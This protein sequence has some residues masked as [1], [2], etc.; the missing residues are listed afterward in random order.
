VVDAARLGQGGIWVV[1][2]SREVHGRDVKLWNNIVT[3]NNSNRTVFYQNL[4]TPIDS[5]YNL[6]FV[7]NAPQRFCR[8][9]S[10]ETCYATLSA[11]QQAAGADAHSL[12]ADPLLN[13][14]DL[15]KPLTA[16]PAIDRG[17][18]ISEVTSDYS[19][20]PRPQGASYDIGAHEAP[21]ACAVSPAGQSFP[22]IASGGSVYV[23]GSGCNWTAASNASWITVSSS[24]SGTGNGTVKYTVAANASGSPRTGMLTVAGQPVIVSQAQQFTDVSPSDVYY[25]YIS[26]IAARGVTA[27]CASGQY[28]PDGLVPR[29]Q[30]AVFIER[31]LGV[32]TPP[33]PSGQTFLDVPPSRWSYTFIED[34]AKRGITVGCGGGYFCPDS[35]VPRDQM[36]TFLERA[37]GR[38]HPA[39][40][41][42]QRFLDVPSSNIFYTFIDSFVAHGAP[43][44]V[45]GVIERGCNTDGQHFCPNNQLS[46]AEMAPWLVV[47]FGLSPGCQIAYSDTAQWRNT[48]MAPKSGSF[49]AELDAAPLS[50]AEDT[51]IALS[52]GSQTSWTGLA[53]IV[54]FNTGNTMDVRNGGI[55]QAQTTVPYTPNTVYHIRM[56]VNVIAHTYSVYVTP[57]GGSEI[58]LAKN[59]AFRTEQQTVSSLNNWVAEAEIGS[60]RAC[61]FIAR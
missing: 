42:T 31:A 51:L 10:G 55:Y 49:T 27:G 39:A 29:E 47:A 12:V 5:D 6:Y 26:E 14:G 19:G 46:R 52:N 56:V 32:F 24:G 61:N 58:L 2:D 34:F 40:P 16:S 22:S 18:T 25:Y 11:W 36:A 53:A 30:M 7:P 8:D 20:I 1:V 9:S 43:S 44:G 45:M 60:V 21:Q 28:C 3:V 4:D 17:A 23:T 38:P 15:Y 41:A 59:Y 37:V 33:V 54:R 13:S 50:S 57:Q 35:I 48:S